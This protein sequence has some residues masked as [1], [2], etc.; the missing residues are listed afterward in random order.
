MPKK[1]IRSRNLDVLKKMPPVYHTIPGQEYDLNNSELVNWLIS[2]DEI[3]Q[4][5]ASYLKS[6]SDYVKY[7]SEKGYW[8]GIDYE[9]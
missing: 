7:D 8:V 1:K 9:G 2:Q 3:K 5:L 6:L 4:W